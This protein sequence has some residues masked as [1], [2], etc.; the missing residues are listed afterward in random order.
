[1]HQWV[2]V[3]ERKRLL[4]RD[5]RRQFHP[6]AAGVE[7]AQHELESGAVDA[8]G[9]IDAA[10]MLDDEVSGRSQDLRVPVVLLV[11]FDEVVHGPAVFVD[12]GHQAI[13]DGLHEPVGDA[14][15]DRTGLGED[16]ELALADARPRDHH[17]AQAV[18][19]AALAVQRDL[20]IVLIH[21]RLHV[22]AARKTQRILHLQP[23]LDRRILEFEMAEDVIGLQRK[24]LLRTD[25]ME[26]RIARPRRQ[27]QFRLGIGAIDL[28][29][30]RTC[31][32]IGHAC[33]C[34]WSALPGRACGA[35]WSSSL[36]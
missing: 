14:V 32:S 3:G 34:L 12:A 23:I 28:W 1:M 30:K 26:M 16:V 25:E 7:A 17:R 11:Q 10:H 13:V 36:K 24:L 9:R 2:G 27:F 6:A 18:G 21:H 33:I 29:R 22:Q 31:P 20:V 8:L 15:A 4:V 19:K 35:H 5:A